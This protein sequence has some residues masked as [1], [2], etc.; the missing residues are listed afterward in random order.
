M[1]FNSIDFV[2]FFILV[3]GLYLLLNH[4]FQNRLLLGA[5]YFFYGCWDWRF[6]TLIL[7]TTVTDWFVGRRLG[8]TDAPAHRKRWL[9]VSVA[10]NL[11][12]LFFFKYCGFFVE[13]AN[14]LLERLG[15]P[16]Q[17]HVLRFILPVGISFYTFQSMSYV[18]DVYRRQL[19]PVSSLEDYALYVSFFP[20]LVAGPIERATH[21]LP[22]VQT[23]RLITYPMIREGL[24][25]ILFGYFKKVVVADNMAPFADMVFNDPHNVHGL[26]IPL[27]LLAFA[28]QIYGD[29]SGYSDI[30][31]GTAKLMG[32][33]I[34]YNFKMP[35]FA[36][37]PRDFWKRWHISLST[38]LRDYLYIPLGG[39]RRGAWGTYRNL[40]ITMLLGGLWHGAAWHFVAWGAYHGMLLSLHRAL[41]PALKR[42][43]VV[44]ARPPLGWVALKTIFFFG[45]TCLGWLLF[46]VQSLADIPALAWNT[47]HPCVLTGKV[48]LLSILCFAGPLVLMD[49]WQERCGDMLAVKRLPAFARLAVYALCVAAIILAGAV[50]KREFIYFQF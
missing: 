22:Q 32:F 17:I 21:L 31:R 48:T 2:L 29:F 33:D 3:Y 24:W 11:G 23:E 46:R 44:H 49:L 12:I 45:L 8:A 30:A 50:D 19:K 13:S 15:A 18:I 4:R 36:V 7:I 16:G 10:V 1:L 43:R 28:F 6:L 34:M 39:N 41:E 5:S 9:A 35:Y 20:Q 25:L 27:G 37:N 38:W 26:A 14:A 42:A 47:F 40:T